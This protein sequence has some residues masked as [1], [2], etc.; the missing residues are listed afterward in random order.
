MAEKRAEE[1]ST[2][3]RLANDKVN[4]LLNRNSELKM[5]L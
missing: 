2:E 5:Q 1:A 4:M 3:L